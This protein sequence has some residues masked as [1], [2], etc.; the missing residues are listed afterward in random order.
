MDSTGLSAISSAS[1][2][3]ISTPISIIFEDIIPDSYY[4]VF[5]M[6]IGDD[7]LSYSYGSLM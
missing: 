3:Y 1:G 6:V 7:P 5:L 4:R 2:E